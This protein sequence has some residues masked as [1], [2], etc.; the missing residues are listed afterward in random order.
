MELTIIILVLIFI[1]AIFI[2]YFSRYTPFAS[3]IPFEQTVQVP[4]SPAPSMRRRRK[5]V[6]KKAIQ[7]IQDP[8]KHVT[9][10]SI[11]TML[12]IRWEPSRLRV[13]A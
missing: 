8:P 9:Y 5:K 2:L 10:T 11:H 12:S 4:P 6:I 1:S 7:V 13:Q 3:S